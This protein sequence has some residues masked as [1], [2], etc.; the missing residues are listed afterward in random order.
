[1]NLLHLESSPRGEQSHSRRLAHELMDA[2]KAAHSGATTVFRDLNDPAIPHVSGEFV[3]AA[4]YA[5][6]E[7]R[8]VTAQGQDSLRLSDEL[9]AELQA[10]DTIVIGF[11]MYNWGIPSV[12]KAYIDHIVRP[13]VTL[14]YDASGPMGLLT[15]KKMYVVSVRGGSGYE[16]AR[17]HTN[18]ADT[19]LRLAF[20]FIGISDLEV[21]A[22]ENQSWGGEGYRTSLE[23]AQTRIAQIAGSA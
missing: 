8:P 23:A 1:M 17:S 10:A 14:G 3:D 4:T 5:V 19:Y 20:G 7:Q 21:I 12:L 11:P 15:G 13:M 9:V 18:F 6:F 2:L 22:V 16:G